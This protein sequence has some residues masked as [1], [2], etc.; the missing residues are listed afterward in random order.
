MAKKR[1]TLN[2]VRRALEA[3]GVKGVE[4]VAGR[5]Y[6]YFWPTDDKEDN[7]MCV[8]PSTSVY[9]CQLNSMSVER[10]IDQYFNLAMEAQR[11]GL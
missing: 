1:V 3:R 4:L 11:A 2:G 8:W 5:G 7:R 9:V 10:W 6:F